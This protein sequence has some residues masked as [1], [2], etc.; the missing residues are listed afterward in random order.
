LIRYKVPGF[1]S[2]MRFSIASL[3]AAPLMFTSLAHALELGNDGSIASVEVHA[4]ASQGFIATTHNNYLSD[5]TTHGSFQFSEVGL[6]FTK[7]VTD[8]LRMGFQL[9]AQNLGPTGSYDVKFDWFYLDYRWKDWLGFRAGRVKIPFGL[10]NEI[11]DVDSARV[12]VLLPQSVYPLESD[13]YLLAQT[14]GEIYGYLKS[15]SAGALEY[16]AYGGTILVDTLVAPST[17]YQVQDLNVPYVVGGR[18]LWEAPL[19]GLRVA[20]SVQALKL[21]ATLLTSA[22][23][24]TP[25]MAAI[26]AASASVE[27][28]AELWVAS[29]EY[30]AHDLVLAAEYSRWYV[31]SSSTNPA[32]IPQT[33]VTTSERGYVMATYRVAKWLQP[34]IYYAVEFPDIDK[35]SGRANFQHDVATTLRFDINSHWL[36]KLEGHFMSGTAELDPSLND[37]VPTSA[38]DENWEVFLAKTTAYF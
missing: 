27:I 9:F 1:I 13:N 24:A 33:P 20:G 15:R 25:T 16:R 35:R 29:V 8:N 10:Y 2:T 36:I 14:G 19:E 34:G 4:F 38:L 23:A 6:N 22:M 28:P 37:N 32:V 18:L 7:T 30:A 17:L 21:D 5:D 12:P 26:P 3:V 11:N 31:S